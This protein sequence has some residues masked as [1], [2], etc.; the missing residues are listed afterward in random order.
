MK[1]NF[2]AIFVCTHYLNI[3]TN[4]LVYR[5]GWVFFSWAILLLWFWYSLVQYLN[6]TFEQC[7]ITVFIEKRLLYLVSKR[8]LPVA[9]KSYSKPRWVTNCGFFFLYCAS[10]LTTVHPKCLLPMDWLTRVAV[11]VVEGQHSARAGWVRIP[12][13]YQVQTLVFSF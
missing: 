7:K 6:T 10:I 13:V 4:S 8:D 5:R 1:C 9:V 2:R 12:D 3:K 11:Q